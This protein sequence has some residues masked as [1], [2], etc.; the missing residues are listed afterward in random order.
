MKRW[1]TRILLVQVLIFVPLIALA[2]MESGNAGKE[3]MMGDGMMG[4]GGMG[5][6]EMMDMHGMGMGSGMM[7]MMK[8]MKATAR[9]DLTPDQR[10]KLQQLHLKHQK[11]AIPLL[12]RIRMAGVEL[13]ELL[14]ADSADLDKV[15][16]KVREKHNAMAELEFSHLS[17]MQQ[18]KALLTAEQRQRLESMMMEMGPEMM[19]EMMPMMSSPSG[20]AKPEKGPKAVPDQPGEAPPKT[21][22]PHG[23]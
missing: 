9:L 15:K 4:G 6:Q 11:E 16:A 19:P 1:I 10:K 23:H 7:D 13:Q 14:L 5:M 8:M 12:G 22:D 3:G 17:L 2:Q 20:P 21:A 18:F